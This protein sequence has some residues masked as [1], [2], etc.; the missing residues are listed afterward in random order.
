MDPYET[1]Y[2]TLTPHTIPITPTISIHALTSSPSSS[3]SPTEKPPLLLLHGF[4]QNLLIW[5]LV[6]PHLAQTYTL[7]LLDLR[8]YGKSSKPRGDGG[9]DGDGDTDH[10]SYSKRTMASDCAAAMSALGFGAF[11]VC[12]HDRGARVAHR[13]CVD[14]PERVRGA[15]VLDVAPT[16]AMY[17]GTD[18]AF[19]RAYWH[20]FFLI[21]K[22][23]LPER[24]MVGGA[25]GWVEGTMGGGEFGVAF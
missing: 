24:L 21:Q 9:G 7:V 8:G 12:G 3:P 1:I 5:H 20:W 10:A 11:F 16:L 19:A 22:A 6:T 18:M 23:P 17:E 25:R 14:Y 2:P 4:P 13:L 15:M